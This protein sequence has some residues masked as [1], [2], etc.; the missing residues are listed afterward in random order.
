MSSNLNEQDLLGMISELD[1]TYK[2]KSSQLVECKSFSKE[3]K[4]REEMSE[5]EVRKRVLKR[6]LD[7]IQREVA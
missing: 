2:D 5:C 4:I 6:K 3:Q 7:S 1:D